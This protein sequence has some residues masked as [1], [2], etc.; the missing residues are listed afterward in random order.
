MSLQKGLIVPDTHRPYHDEAA[1]R[2]MLQVGR[3]MKP[4]TVITI[5]DLA[6]F[7]AVSSHSKDPARESQLQAEME[8]VKDALSQLERLKAQK[9]VFLAGN[10]CDRLDRYLRDRAPELYRLVGGVDKVL[11]LTARGWEYVPYKGYYQIGKVY[12]THDTGN[13]GRYATFRAMDTFEHSVVIG[14]HHRL[15]YAVEGNAVGEAKVAAQFGWL[16]DASKIDYMHRIKVKRDWALGFGTFVHDTSTGVVYLQPI[17][18]VRVK[19]HY[20]CVWGERLFT[21]PVL[22]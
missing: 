17:P 4:H 15:Q 2:L 3:A 10:H 14:H 19:D 13:G 1:W 5:G 12:F 18:I 8:D 7:Y 11:E 22:S 16:G 21:Q 20:T 6:D 9:N